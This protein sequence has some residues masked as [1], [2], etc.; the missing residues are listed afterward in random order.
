MKLILDCK[1]ASFGSTLCAQIS[2]E[3]SQK[4]TL[5]IWKQL[6]IN[7]FR[8]IFVEFTSVSLHTIILKVQDE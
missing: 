2:R 8:Q 3:R 1:N 6:K 5:N 4:T 7:S